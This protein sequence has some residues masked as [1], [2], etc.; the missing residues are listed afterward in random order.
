MPAF[1]HTPYDGSKTPF[2][3][4]LEPLDLAR[5]I[6]PD[7]RLARDLDEKERLLRDRRDIVFAAEA[8]TEA[9]QREVRDLL[10]AHLPR[11]FPDLYQAEPG[12]IRVT[13]TG[14]T[15]ALDEDDPL[16]AAPS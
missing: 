5:W 11:R 15:I 1:A 16:I 7:E 12:G 13:P 10:A 2:T 6:E 9:A 3:I 8:G 4:G 14:G